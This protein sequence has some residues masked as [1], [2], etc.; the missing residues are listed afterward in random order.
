MSQSKVDKWSTKKKIDPATGK[1]ISDLNKKEY[2]AYQQ[3]QFMPR[4]AEILNKE[5]MTLQ[6]TR[7]YNKK[8]ITNS[9]NAKISEGTQEGKF[10]TNCLKAYLNND[11]GFDYYPPRI[12][13]FVKK[14]VEH[15]NKGNSSL[16]DITLNRTEGKVKD[17]VDVNMNMSDLRPDQAEIEEQDNQFKAVQH[18]PAEIE[19]ETGSQTAQ[20]GRHSELEG[21]AI[22]TPYEAE[23]AVNKLIKDKQAGEEITDN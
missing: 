23:K 7:E 11:E 2:R 6:E 14:I 17:V 5:E 18:N 21:Q 19:Q 1:K 15:A 22:Q 9:R 20:N 4:S 10:I 8:P 13:E 16:V 12:Q 3:R